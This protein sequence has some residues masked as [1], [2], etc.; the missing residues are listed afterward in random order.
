[1]Q[2]TLASIDLTT[3]DIP[4]DNQTFI[5]ILRQD[6]AGQQHVL[7]VGRLAE[8]DTSVTVPVVLPRGESR[9]FYEL[10]HPTTLGS[11][12]TEITNG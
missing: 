12:M 2:E 4:I 9:Y 8:G 10:Y 1:M 11:A 7:F 3:S 6:K 5:R